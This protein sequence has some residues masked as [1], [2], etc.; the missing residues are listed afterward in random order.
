MSRALRQFQTQKPDRQPPSCHSYH[1]R[2]ASGVVG[3]LGG[4]R[5]MAMQG[6][7]SNEC[8]HCGQPLSFP[9]GEQES[10]Y[11]WRVQG[12]AEINDWR[13]VN[14]VYYATHGNPHMM[15]RMKAG[16]L[17]AGCDQYHVRVWLSGLFRRAR[18]RQEPART[19]YLGLHVATNNLPSLESDGFPWEGQTA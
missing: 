6:V 4:A 1:E 3:I 9:G 16:D 14:A 2:A 7:A 12:G 17:L 10:E 15:L 8:P 5:K 18:T 13:K 19:L 11:W